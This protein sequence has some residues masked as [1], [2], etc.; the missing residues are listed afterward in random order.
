[1]DT[2]KLNTIAIIEP[3][4][5]GHRF[6]YL[7]RVVDTVANMGITP[8]VATIEENIQNPV[9]LGLKDNYPSLKIITVKAPNIIDKFGIREICWWQWM[10]TAYLQCSSVANIDKVF[11]PYLDYLVRAIPIL[12]SPFKKA[13]F[14]GIVMQQKFHHKSA[15]IESPQSPYAFL[16]QYLF[17]RTISNKNIQHIY[18]IDETLCANYDS[19][20]C[21]IKYLADPVSLTKPVDKK[22]AKTLL[23]INTEKP[24]ILVF[25]AI[26][27][28]KGIESI[29]KTIHEFNLDVCLV[30]AGNQD[31]AAHRIL[32]SESAK[33]LAVAGKIVHFNTFINENDEDLFYCA[34]DI[35]WCGYLNHYT[36][37]GVLIKAASSQRPVLSCQEGLLGYL[38]QKHQLGLA[39]DCQTPKAVKTAIH[40]LLTESHDK[41][42]DARASFA[43]EHSVESFH[44]SL[45]EYLNSPHASSYQSN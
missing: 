19:K 6:I 15:G 17:N 11:L 45:S 1:M 3:L 24:I 7:K 33:E 42:I 4:S 26:S 39:I 41:V 34:S 28:R 35:I 31:E 2:Q 13:P 16:D 21:K 12:G 10:K 9:L 32:H 30:L 29:I 23:G 43:L 38:T 37:S 40:S 14:S 22:T 18:S 36:M 27:P 5:D 8:V 20:T 25:G 44:Q